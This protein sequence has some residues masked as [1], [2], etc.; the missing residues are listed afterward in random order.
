[1]VR[2]SLLTF[3]MFL[4]ACSDDFSTL[5]YDRYLGYDDVCNTNSKYYDEAMCIAWKDGAYH[6]ETAR[7]DNTYTLGPVRECLDNVNTR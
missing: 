4:C 7:Y 5:C 6:V 3:F 1:M 2:F